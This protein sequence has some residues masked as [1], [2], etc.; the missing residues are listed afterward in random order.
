MA[1]AFITTILSKLCCW[2]LFAE[3]DRHALLDPVMADATECQFELGQE[4]VS[5]GDVPDRLYLIEK[6]RVRITRHGTSGR[7]WTLGTSGPG[8]LLG[9][10]ALLA[11]GIMTATCR[12]SETTKAIAFSKA[13]LMQQI[14]RRFALASSLRLW[15]RFHFALR[16]VRQQA[17]LGFMSAPS[18]IKLIVRCIIELRSLFL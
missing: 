4:I 7:E 1:G 14:A 3:L 6:G 18:F 15:I 12:A 16:F 11:P 10:Y 17:S 9:D 13:I 8:E 5:E 2:P